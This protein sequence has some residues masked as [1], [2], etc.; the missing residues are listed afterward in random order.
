MQ[1]SDDRAKI[2]SFD[3]KIHIPS[4][5]V[6]NEIQD[7]LPKIISCILLKLKRLFESQLLS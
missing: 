5:L 4:R 2:V 3:I 1:S 6:L 7:A